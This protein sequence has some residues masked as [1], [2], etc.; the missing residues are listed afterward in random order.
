MDSVE[1]FQRKYK[2]AQSS[3]RIICYFVS[4]YKMSKPFKLGNPTCNTFPG[5]IPW[6]SFP[7]P[8]TT[9]FLT[10]HLFFQLIK[11]Y[12]FLNLSLN[13]T[14]HGKLLLILKIN[15]KWLYFGFPEPQIYL[16]SAF[17]YTTVAYLCLR[18]TAKLNILYKYP[19]S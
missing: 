2:L 11:S 18:V 9:S 13:A 7:H 5:A 14:S 17:I 1:Y 19:L 8:T 6:A 15:V 4:K 12:Y 3:W 16:M 10:S